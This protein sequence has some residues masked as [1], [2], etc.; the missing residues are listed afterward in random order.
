MMGGQIFQGHFFQRLEIFEANVIA[1]LRTHGFPIPP[2]NPFKYQ[3]R[4]IKKNQKKNQ[5]LEARLRKIALGKLSQEDGDHESGKTVQYAGCEHE[6]KS[7][8]EVVKVIK[9]K[10]QN[11]HNLLQLVDPEISHKFYSADISA[12][13]YFGFRISDHTR[14]GVNNARENILV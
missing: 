4:Q 3:G 8:F 6:K 12:V 13:L 5:A 1:E 2:F 7:C 10:S 9:N 11:S 14:N